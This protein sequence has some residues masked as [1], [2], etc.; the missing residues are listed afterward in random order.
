[1]QFSDLVRECLEFEYSRDRLSGLTIFRPDQVNDDLWKK[2]LEDVRRSAVRTFGDKV[3]KE[4]W[5]WTGYEERVL[6]MGLVADKHI[7][8]FGAARCNSKWPIRS[9]GMQYLKNKAQT[10][11]KKRSS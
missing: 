7:D 11:R 10:A 6:V 1:M 2:I 5:K 3:D 4:T 9:L 8:I